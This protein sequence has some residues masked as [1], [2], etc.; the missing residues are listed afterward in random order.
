MIIK[1]KN[2]KDIQVDHGPGTLQSLKNTNELITLRD[3]IIFFNFKDTKN[4]YQIG[5]TIVYPGC[6]TVGHAHDDREEIYNILDGYGKMIVEEHEFEIEPGD[7][8]IVPHKKFH[9]MLNTSNTPL[10]CFW[11]VK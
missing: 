11:I 10:K 1:K 5:Y 7:T 8:F 4:K 6:R 9:V 3:T 2:C